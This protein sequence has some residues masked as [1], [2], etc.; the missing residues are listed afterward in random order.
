LTTLLEPAVSEAGVDLWELEYNSRAGGGLLRIYIDRQDGITVDDC[1]RVSHAV[2]A[3]LDERDPIKGEYTLEVSSPGLDRVLRKREHF[4]RFAGE[5]V[6]LETNEPIDGR[7]RFSGKL[8]AVNE[9]GIE[10]NVES[11][12]VAI[13]FAAIHKARLVPTE[14]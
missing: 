4:A 3:V 8:S 5:A 14:S 6:K 11:R 12:T 2:S 13:P 9:R 10:L 1:E 7:R